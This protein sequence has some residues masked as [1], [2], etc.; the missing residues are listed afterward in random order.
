MKKELRQWQK[1]VRDHRNV[2]NQLQENTETKIEKI[3]EKIWTNDSSLS[4][5]LE[6]QVNLIRIALQEKIMGLEK[7][8]YQ[9][10][11]RVNLV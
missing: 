2:M 1:E 8:V 7:L 6:R 11:Y 10:E 9:N 4:E 3:E 5:D